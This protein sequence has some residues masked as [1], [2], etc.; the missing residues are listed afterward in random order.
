MSE[1][2]SR[3]TSQ[4]QRKLPRVGLRFVGG[5][6]LAGSIFCAAETVIHQLHAKSGVDEVQR[7]ETALLPPDELGWLL[8]EDQLTQERI[9][10]AGQESAVRTYGVGSLVLGLGGAGSVLVAA[11]LTPRGESGGRTAIPSP[12]PPG[13][14]TAAPPS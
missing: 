14:E 9:I 3:A 11:A 4:E 7:I 13:V 1:F 10:L 2:S 8:R 5:A 6:A 12:L